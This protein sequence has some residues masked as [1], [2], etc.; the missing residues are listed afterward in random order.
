MSKITKKLTAN[1]AEWEKQ[2]KRLQRLLTKLEQEGMTF[3]HSPIPETPHRI[4]QKKLE[5][6]K[7]I[8]KKTLKSLADN[9]PPKP[10]YQPSPPSKP[11]TRAKQP[12]PFEPHKPRS[13][14][15]ETTRE[16]LREAGKARKGRPT[17]A[18]PPSRKGTTHTEETKKK[19]SEG[20]KASAQR[21]KE[22]ATP[23]KRPPMSEE[24]KKK[25]SESMKKRWEEKR[26]QE[27]VETTPDFPQGWYEALYELRNLIQTGKNRNISNYLLSLLEDEI[28]LAEGGEKEVGNRLLRSRAEAISMAQGACFDSGAET[29]A[30]N[31]YALARLITNGDLPPSAAEDIELLANEDCPN[32]R[33]RRPR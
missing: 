15:S 27:E 6:I 11:R 16:K 3:T 5:D 12:E 14:V 30:N 17:R 4:T 21:R 32:T 31:A 23:I 25:L 7:S 22:Q 33:R 1:Q 29:V 26:K 24:T 8:T 2:Q 20:V 28:D 18:K 9:Q 13:P 10:T 19:I